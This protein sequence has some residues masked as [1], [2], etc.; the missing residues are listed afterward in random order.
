MFESASSQPKHFQIHN[1]ALIFVNLLL[2]FVNHLLH[3]GLILFVDEADAFLRKRSSETIS[4]D[5]RLGCLATKV[6]YS[7]FA[8]C[9]NGNITS[10]T[11]IS[12]L[13]LTCFY[14]KLSVVN[15]HCKFANMQFKKL[16]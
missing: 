1:P 11:G 7:N 5:L 4:E 6:P 12:T 8:K 16:P 2:I 3:S 15:V 9:E 10:K 14:G 13:Y